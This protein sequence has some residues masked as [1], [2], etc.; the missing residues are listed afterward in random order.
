MN[1]INHL[2]E[3]AEEIRW[4][5]VLSNIQAAVSSLD[6][7]DVEAEIENLKIVQLCLTGK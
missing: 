6:L 1:E 5:V 7:Q 2:E 3:I 4:H